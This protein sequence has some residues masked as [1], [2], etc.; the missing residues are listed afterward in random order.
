MDLAGRE[1]E[2]VLEMF[3]VRVLF[4]DSSIDYPS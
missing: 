3:V 2:F 4:V 1:L